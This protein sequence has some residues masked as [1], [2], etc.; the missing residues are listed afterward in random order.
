M[1][2]QELEEVI[3]SSRR[4]AAQLEQQHRELQ[5]KASALQEEKM[6][7]QHRLNAVQ[8]RVSR[9]EAEL[10]SMSKAREVAEADARAQG[11]TVE[12]LRQELAQRAEALDKLRSDVT[13][14]RR[15]VTDA[16]EGWMQ[17]LA[18]LLNDA[19]A[20]F[21][22]PALT[23]TVARVV[24]LCTERKYKTD[25]LATQLQHE[26]DVMQR[27]LEQL[28]QQQQQQID[29]QQQ[30]S[31]SHEPLDSVGALHRQATHPLTFEEI[32]QQVRGVVEHKAGTRFARFEVCVDLFPSVLA[33]FLC[34]VEF[35]FCL[36]SSFLLFCLLF[37]L[38]P[39][40]QLL[41]TATQ[42]HPEGRTHFFRVRTGDDSCV[43]LCLFEDESG[44]VTLQYATVSC[45]HPL[46]LMC[47]HV[48]VEA[49]SISSQCCT[50]QTGSLRSG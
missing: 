8:E 38:F 14:W 19:P 24:Q 50:L 16:G 6:S 32:A 33:C 42:A 28:R 25:E 34:C 20:P 22:P 37:T 3:Q 45:S 10:Q 43:W 1:R 9:L 7:H 11:S 36:R 44:E 15:D 40:H 5:Q 21:S 27:Q 47:C 18:F 2:Q 12:A 35:R 41:Q 30:P 23:A 26:R 46:L 4:S 48:L 13:S 17:S 31:L 39:L 29:V 49:A